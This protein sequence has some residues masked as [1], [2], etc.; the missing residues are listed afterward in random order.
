VPPS[1]AK[2]S[3][4]FHRS[5]GHFTVKMSRRV[6]GG[7]AWR[8][9][10]WFRGGKRT[11]RQF[12]IEREAEQHG[13]SIW[14]QYQARSLAGMR[15]AQPADLNGFI[16]SFL[17]RDLSM[18][19]K[20]EYQQILTRFCGFVGSS[21]KPQ[22]ISRVDVDLWFE[23]LPIGLSDASKATY[24][25]TIKA[26]F[27]FGVKHGWLES[28]PARFRTQ[29]VKRKPVVYLPYERWDDF[30]GACPPSHR[31]RCQFMLFTGIRS[32]EMIHARWSWVTGDLLSIQPAPSDNWN[33]KWGSARQ[34]P[35]CSQAREALEKAR[36]K[37]Q[38][39][40]YIF[41]N[42]R[43]SA[44]NASRLNKIACQRVGIPYFKPHSLRA[45]FA[46]RML[47]L[48]VDLLTVQRLL[49]HSD[50]RVLLEY[51]AGV[52]TKDLTDAVRLFE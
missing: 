45:S 37:W 13:V 6:T 22:N 10:W 27:N 46:T 4:A 9:W 31:I 30:L 49:G 48:G 1:P 28:N 40:D 36:L 26:F 43:L 44:W 12:Q 41:A 35:L 19:T 3:P 42:H 16:D 25:R 5:D 33:P 24:L 47:S 18:K 2:T 39:S 32:G 15:N 8:V 14:R 29:R 50:Y 52:N 7:G 34:I 38:T 17:D 21:R 20:K 11:E 23:S 51:Y